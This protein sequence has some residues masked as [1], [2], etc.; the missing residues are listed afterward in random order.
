M[1][2]IFAST[3]TSVTPF[4][5]PAYLSTSCGTTGDYWEKWVKS[6]GNLVKNSQFISMVAV[7]HGMVPHVRKTDIHIL[8]EK[9]DAVSLEFHLIRIMTLLAEGFTVR[10]LLLFSMYKSTCLILSYIA[11]MS[12]H[13]FVS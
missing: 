2:N 5:M 3:L 7:A 10:F 4:R 1:T 11:C 6:R 12:C 9:E 8:H 13:V